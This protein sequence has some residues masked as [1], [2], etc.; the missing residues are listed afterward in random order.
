M[1]QRSAWRSWRTRHVE[2]AHAG[3]ATNDSLQYAH[4]GGARNDSWQCQQQSKLQHP[5]TPLLSPSLSP[6]LPRPPLYRHQPSY[7]APH[8]WLRIADVALL[9]HWLCHGY[10]RL[11]KSGSLAQGKKRTRKRK[12]KGVTGGGR[13]LRRLP[14][15]LS[16]SAV[17]GLSAHRLAVLAPV[18]VC[19]CV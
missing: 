5:P 13:R 19:L 10:R 18:R 3:G 15:R 8:Y 16:K 1:R 17:P 12:R 11:W 9:C 6:D 7:G 2:Y 4:A 14:C